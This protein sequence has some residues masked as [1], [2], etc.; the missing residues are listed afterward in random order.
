MQEEAGGA[1]E[2]QE[3]LGKPTWAPQNERHGHRELG[4]AGIKPEPPIQLRGL[5]SS[6]TPN[7]IVPGTVGSVSKQE[8]EITHQEGGGRNAGKE[9]VGCEHEEE[10]QKSSSGP[11]DPNNPIG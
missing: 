11:I 4:L 3:G 9:A 5:P 1:D 2:D 7:T 10:Q 6:G 8:A